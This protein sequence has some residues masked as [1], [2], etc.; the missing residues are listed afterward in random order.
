M[1]SK[2]RMVAYINTSGNHTGLIPAIY[3][4]PGSKRKNPRL[5]KNHIR[6]QLRFILYGIWAQYIFIVHLVGFF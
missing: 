3:A 1:V 5:L 4:V 2:D 6:V